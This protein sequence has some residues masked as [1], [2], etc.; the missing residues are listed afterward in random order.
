MSVTNHFQGKIQS[1]NK[2]PHPLQTRTR[3]VKT[4]VVSS[5]RIPQIR[6]GSEWRELRRVRVYPKP[7]QLLAAQSDSVLGFGS[8]L[9]NLFVDGDG[10]SRAV[11]PL[12]GSRASTVRQMPSF[13]HCHADVTDLSCDFT[14]GI[15]FFPFKAKR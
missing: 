11:A 3:S 13:P 7:L 8:L 12:P 10:N 15:L 4:C 5:L 14:S 2:T 6:C 1:V 9:S